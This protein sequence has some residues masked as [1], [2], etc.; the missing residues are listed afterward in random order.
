MHPEKRTLLCVR[1]SR[2]CPELEE[3]LNSAGSGWRVLHAANLTE[4]RFLAQRYQ[5][6]VGLMVLGDAPSAIRKP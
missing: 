1:M 2:H 5:P 3:Q 4:A 6:T